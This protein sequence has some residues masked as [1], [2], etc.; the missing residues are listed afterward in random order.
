MALAAPPEFETG[1][2]EFTYGFSARVSRNLQLPPNT[3]RIERRERA[4]SLVSRRFGFLKISGTDSRHYR[5][6]QFLWKQFPPRLPASPKLIPAVERRKIREQGGRPSSSCR[7]TIHTRYIPAV[8]SL[9]P[10]A[11]LSLF[12]SPLHSRSPFFPLFF[13]LSRAFGALRAA[14]VGV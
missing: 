12:L 1:T 8:T 10:S 6:I 2:A 7:R 14:L 3:G 13:V 9:P 4:G 5:E 11:S